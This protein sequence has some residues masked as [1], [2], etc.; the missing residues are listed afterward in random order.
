VKCNSGK[1]KKTFSTSEGPQSYQWK[2]E[3]LAYLMNPK[4]TVVAKGGAAKK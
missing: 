1:K 2:N 3:C 4:E